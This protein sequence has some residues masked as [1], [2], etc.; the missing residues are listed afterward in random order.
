MKKILVMV[1]ATILAVCAFTGCG[2]NNAASDM[3]SA[4][5]DVASDAASGMESMGDAMSGGTVSDTDGIIGN[6]ATTN[7]ATEGTSNV[8][9]NTSGQN[10]TEPSDALI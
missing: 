8:E 9:D 3:G 4:V 5:S 2:T 10:N 1:I 7:G 6:E